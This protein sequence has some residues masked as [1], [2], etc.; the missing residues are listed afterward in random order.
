MS[1][2]ITYRVRY[3]HQRDF[4]S[5]R[6][7]T[8]AYTLCSDGNIRVAFS[9]YNPGDA[10]L[11]ISFNKSTGRSL[12]NSR[13]M[14]MNPETSVVV[15]FKKLFSLGKAVEAKI[16][17]YCSEL[18]LYDQIITKDMFNDYFYFHVK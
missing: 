14:S 10:K 7:A 11:G 18:Y 4:F 16:K 8:L 3:L 5:N 15:P 2:Y 6:R 12:S 17:A 9:C 1:D 13:L